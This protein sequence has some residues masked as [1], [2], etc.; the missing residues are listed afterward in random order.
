MQSRENRKVEN[1]GRQRVKQGAKGVK[2]W[3]G[4]RLPRIRHQKPRSSAKSQTQ[5]HGLNKS[6]QIV[7]AG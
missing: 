5:P 6:P 7:C 4:I 1:T 3:R 2:N